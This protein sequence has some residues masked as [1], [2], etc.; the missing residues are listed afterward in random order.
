MKSISFDLRKISKFFLQFLFASIA[1]IIVG[2]GIS[3]FGIKAGLLFTLAFCAPLLVY[4]KSEHLLLFI[5]VFVYLLLGPIDY[6]AKVSLYWIPFLVG[7][8]LY[9]VQAIDSLRTDSA[10]DFRKLFSINFQ[11]LGILLFT[12]SIAISTAVY[13]DGFLSFLSSFR[14]YFFL[15]SVYIATSLFRNPKALLKKY[16]IIIIFVFICQIPMILY[17]SLVIVPR[18]HDETRWDAV[19]GTF[20]GNSDSGGDSGSL[21]VFLFSQLAI[22]YFLFREKYFPGWIYAIMVAVTILFVAL[23]EVKIAAI[24]I[25]L[26][27]IGIQLTSKRINIFHLLIYITFGLSLSALVLLA[28]DQISQTNSRD[29]SGLDPVSRIQLALKY[30]F[31]A[32][33]L[34]VG[35]AKMVGRAAAIILWWRSNDFLVDP[36]GYI[37]GN[38]MGALAISRDGLGIVYRKFYPLAVDTN[39][40]AVLLWESG[41]VG[42]FGFC[43]FLLASYRNSYYIIQRADISAFEMAIMKGIFVAL[44]M[45]MVTLPY[46]KSLIR[47][48]PA[49]QFSLLFFCGLVAL[50][51]RKIPNKK[52]L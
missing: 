9:V 24:L 43:I 20:I 21:A 28:Y 14:D 23:A 18:R 30:T 25:L 31:D 48:S 35:R 38:G 22:G 49:T 15:F 3:V 4:T 42:F 37:F 39:A 36:L 6:I 41:I 50:Y 40:A 1:S 5:A 47:G 32:D 29:N 45:Y 27:I 26:A 16:W 11:G 19:V 34:G 44:P 51:Y 13:N 10:T 7:A 8:A 52:S 12:V 33:Q 17:Q 2:L 46:S